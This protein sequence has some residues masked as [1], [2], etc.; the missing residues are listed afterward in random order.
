MSSQHRN[1]FW[2][3]VRTLRLGAEVGLFLTCRQQCLWVNFRVVTEACDF[4]IH[5]RTWR[6]P[7][8]L[9][10]PLPGLRKWPD[11]LGEILS[12]PGGGVFVRHT[13][14]GV[15]ADLIR[16]PCRA[17][18]KIPRSIAKERLATGPVQNGAG[19]TESTLPGY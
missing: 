18:L 17:V 12:A 13:E 6:S 5:L 2:E 16:T 7:A 9:S 19:F 15:H 14:Q 1:D 3:L 4:P 8:R 10:R 11:I